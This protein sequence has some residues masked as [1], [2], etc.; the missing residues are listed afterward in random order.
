MKT[1]A[2]ARYALAILGVSFLA[3]SARAQLIGTSGS[4]LE[5]PT[6]FGGYAMTVFADDLRRDFHNVSSVVSPLGDS[7]SFSKK[8]EHLEIGRGWCT[9]SNGYD[10]DVYFVASGKSVTL[11]LPEQTKA[12]YFYAEPNLFADRNITVSSGGV[13]LSEE[14]FGNSGAEFFG[15][16]TTGTTALTSITI[17]SNDCSG[18]AIGEFGI[19]NVFALPSPFI[20]TAVPEPSTY[21]LMGAM[22]LCGLVAARRL[23]RGKA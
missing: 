9:W 8:L 17:T 3:S 12:F 23:K 14:V 7:L 22:A 19:G 11:T 6:V 18:F 16:Y 13:V 15:F 1:F 21:A 20:S 5:P 2:L 10:G 4:T